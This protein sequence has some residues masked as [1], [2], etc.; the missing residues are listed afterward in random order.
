MDEPNLQL[1]A[2]LKSLG[3]E[4]GVIGGMVVNHAGQSLASTLPAGMDPEV[5]GLF[6]LGSYMNCEHVIKKIGHD[7]VYHVVVQDEQGYILISDFGDG[8]LVLLADERAVVGFVPPLAAIA[9][10]IQAG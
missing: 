8:L 10:L 5:I 1:E 4:N 6:A 3:R 2:L 7:R 9:A